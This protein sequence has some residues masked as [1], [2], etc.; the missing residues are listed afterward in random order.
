M[1]TLYNCGSS[2]DGVIRC[3]FALPVHMHDGEQ[4]E[5]VQ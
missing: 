4:G 2:L 3:N 1:D 5:P